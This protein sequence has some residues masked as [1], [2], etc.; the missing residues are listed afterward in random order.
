MLYLGGE[1]YGKSFR[2]ISEAL[3][4]SQR[5]NNSNNI[6]ICYA[7]LA[8]IAK[9]QGRLDISK[10]HYEQ[11]I[12]IAKETNNP[13][14]TAARQR[15]LAIVLMMIGNLKQAERIILDSTETYKKIKVDFLHVAEITRAEIEFRKGDFSKSLKIVEQNIDKL[16]SNAHQQDAWIEAIVLWMD[17]LLQFGKPKK[18]IKVFSENRKQIGSTDSSISNRYHFLYLTLADAQQKTKDLEIDATL[19]IIEKNLPEDTSS[20][21]PKF[22]LR[23]GKVYRTVGNKRRQQKYFRLAKK[24]LSEQ[25]AQIEDVEIRKQFL[26][27]VP[28]NKEISQI[29]AI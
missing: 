2:L 12:Q 17:A 10:L 22:Y 3:L 5:I 14:A 27:N 28:A 21:A 24:R 8:D 25:S 1:E 9:A 4:L 18:T 15:E 23:L 6:G 13:R 19:N 26:E 7:H 11:S 29:K 20:R 16:K